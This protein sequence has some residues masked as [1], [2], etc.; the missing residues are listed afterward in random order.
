MSGKERRGEAGECMEGE[1]A[2]A[3]RSQNVFLS[4]APV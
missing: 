1:S 2:L 4:T 3:T